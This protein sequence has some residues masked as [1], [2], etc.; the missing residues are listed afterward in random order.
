[1]KA[2]VVTPTSGNHQPHWWVRISCLKAASRHWQGVAR[3]PGGVGLP[4]L[5]VLPM[6]PGSCLEIKVTCLVC[7]FT[8]RVTPPHVEERA[9][10]L[11]H[12]SWVGAGGELGPPFR[13][14]VVS[15][16]ILKLL[17]L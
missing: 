14:S 15:K 12:G 3:D 7:I 10:T 8:K 11:G 5:R 4:S 2:S 16:C 6:C 9:G 17:V 13:L 1:M